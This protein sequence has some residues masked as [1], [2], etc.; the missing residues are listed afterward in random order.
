MLKYN[1]IALDVETLMWYTES[2]ADMYDKE[3][4]IWDLQTI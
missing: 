3:T 4:M 2:A 1:Q